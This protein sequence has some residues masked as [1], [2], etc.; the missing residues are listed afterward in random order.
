MSEGLPALAG[1]R[2]LISVSMTNELPYLWLDSVFL[3]AGLAPALELLG[4]MDEV[5][6]PARAVL[7]VFFG[8]AE[9]C[10]TL[11][12]AYQ[13]L[14]ELNPQIGRQLV[15]LE[16]TPPVLISVICINPRADEF[17]TD[18][19]RE[20]LPRLA[21]SREGRQLLT[22]FGIEGHRPFREEYLAGMREL[23]ERARQLR[24]AARP[25]P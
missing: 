18:T 6:T 17:V 12:S 23:V 11:E 15:V 25:A 2:L 7:P 4:S 9:A 10:V 21:E 16:S 3:A 14:T 20:E 22:L 24:A 8:Q 19:I 1:K 5:N 13:T